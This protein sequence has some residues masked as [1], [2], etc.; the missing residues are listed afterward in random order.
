MD[1][2]NTVPVDGGGETVVSLPNPI[3]VDNVDHAAEA[4]ARE[5]EKAAA[6]A[7]RAPTAREALE[8]AARKVDE[9]NK[10]DD[11]PKDK[12]KPLEAK[13]P[14]ARDEQGKYKGKEAEGAKAAGVD[15]KPTSP[16]EKGDP[17][18]ADASIAKP[19]EPGKPFVGAGKDGD[20]P[21]AR[22]EA[23]AR[24]SSDAKAEWERAPDSVKAEVN[25]AVRELETGIEEHRKRW[26]PIKEYDALARHHGT[27]LRSALD[28]YVSMDMALND[29]VVHGLELIC[30]DKGISLRDVAA[31]VLDQTPDQ[32]TGKQDE[33]I[34]ELRAMVQDLQKQ[35]GGVVGNM[36]QNVMSASEQE[37]VAFAADHAHFDEL[38][39][40]I[41]GHI[42]NDGLS[43]PEAYDR[44]LTNAQEQARRLGFI[45][46]PH[47]TP[48]APAA[49]DLIAQTEKGQKSIAGAPSAGSAPASKKPS[50]SIKDSVRRAFQATN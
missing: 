3:N 47:E 18:A 11:P 44:A 9:Q 27:D 21:A 5:A 40:V 25:R 6:D 43:L 8:K 2:L 48:P 38:S 33:T 49:V 45:N 41:A 42:T 1:E 30:Q 19:S 10:S 32:V 12:P 31:R 23:P 28:R 39:A 7:K 26:E 36:H 35:V 22:H 17:P 37:V 20:G 4:K 14:A 13:T 29:D 15:P 24:F 46:Q 50:S 34:R 16:V